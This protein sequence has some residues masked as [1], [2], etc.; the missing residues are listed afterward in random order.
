MPSDRTVPA[1]SA[2]AVVLREAA[3]ERARQQD[4]HTVTAGGAYSN[5]SEIQAEPIR[6]PAESIQLRLQARQEDDASAET[7]TIVLRPGTG[8]GTRCIDHTGAWFHPKRIAE[9]ALPSRP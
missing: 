7:A 4:V 2:Y 1:G 3:A 8:A 9:A 6:N 5:V